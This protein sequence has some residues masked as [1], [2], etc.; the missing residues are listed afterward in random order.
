MQS[1]DHLCIEHFGDGTKC[2]GSENRLQNA[3]FFLSSFS[4]FMKYL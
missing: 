1:V 2:G 3:A 4:F